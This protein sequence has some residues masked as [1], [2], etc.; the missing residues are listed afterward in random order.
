[1]SRRTLLVLIAVAVVL[2]P[3]IGLPYA[4]L[5]G[6]LPLLG[7]FTLLIV[8]LPSRTKPLAH[9]REEESGA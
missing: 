1:M 3:F 9:A 5:M 7:V 8:L 6:V 2:S 4:W